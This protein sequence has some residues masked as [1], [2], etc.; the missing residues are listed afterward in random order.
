MT[1]FDN[2]FHLD[3]RGR[4]VEAAKEF[5]RAG[6]TG[7]LLVV[8][9]HWDERDRESM[10]ARYDWTVAMAQ[11]VRS[12]TGLRVGVALAPHPATTSVLRRDHGMTRTAI[13]EFLRTAV[14]LAVR[15]V[16]ERRAVALGELGRPH[17]ETEAVDT[18]LA[19]AC[20]RYAME[21][22][23]V[24]RCPII[25][26]TESETPKT[27]SDMAAIARSAGYPIERLVKHYNGPIVDVATTHGIVPSLIAAEKNVRAAL[28]GGVP[29]RFFMETD[30]LDDPQR[31]G[32]VL[33]P[34]T[35]P[36]VTAK[37][38]KEGLIT[39]DQANRIH[40]EEPVRF[41]GL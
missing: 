4:G 30:Y 16:E 39:A 28:A 17:Y 33:G 5:Q 14:D 21:R 25:L 8:K 1:G 12:E 7:M 19:E 22:A 37:L 27:Y 15:E 13:E 23:K 35:V 18:E 36:R 10:A 6:G 11:R 38:L 24:V 26:H 31:P 34:K 3:E 2:H 29:D 41:Y 40:V 32:A 9:P 20:L